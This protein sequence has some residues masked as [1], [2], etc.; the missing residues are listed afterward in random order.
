[1]HLHR[2][3][4]DAD[5]VSGEQDPTPILFVLANDL[6]SGRSSPANVSKRE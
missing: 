5:T 3:P 1:M 6:Q 4:R 2:I